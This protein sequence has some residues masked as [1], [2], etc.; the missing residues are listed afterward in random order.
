MWRQNQV[1]D[2]NGLPRF[3]KLGNRVFAVSAAATRHAT[4]TPLK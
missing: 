3:I 2:A 4:G 1:N